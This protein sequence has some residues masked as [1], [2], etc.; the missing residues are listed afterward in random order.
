[1][2]RKKKLATAG[3][4][5]LT[6]TA[7]VIAVASGVGLFGLSQESPRVGKLSPID[8][9]RTTTS[10]NPDV[11]SIVVDDTT[12]PTTPSRGDDDATRPATAGTTPATGGAGTTRAT[13]PDG[14]DRGGGDRGGGDNSGPGSTSSGRDLDEDD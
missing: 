4:V 7:A 12:T 9:T 13:T 3:A 10:T 5:S 1:M 6:A 8:A 11:Q 2:E 14:D